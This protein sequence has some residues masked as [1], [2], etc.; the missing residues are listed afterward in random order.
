MQTQ[1]FKVSISK[2]KIAWLKKVMLKVKF[3][4]QI[5]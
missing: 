3:G 4:I 5:N 1:T 2:N